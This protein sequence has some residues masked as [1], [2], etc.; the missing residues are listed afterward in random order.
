MRIPRIYF[1]IKITVG[2]ELYLT[3]EIYRHLI[4]V[5]KHNI[6][7]EVLIFNG[8]GG[9]YKSKILKKENN[10]Y[11]LILK[12]IDI[13]RESNIFI[14]LGLSLLP[15]KKMDIV[16]QKS[17]ELGVNKI[18][19]LDVSRSKVNNIQK[20]HKKL[21]HWKKII[22]SA[23]EQSGRTKIPKI[24]MPIKLHDWMREINENDNF[25]MFHPDSLQQY[26]EINQI[27]NTFKLLVGPEGGFSDEEID[28]GSSHRAKVISLSK[29]VMRA[30]TAAIFVVGLTQNLFGDM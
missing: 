12:F 7:D 10:F 25:I 28:I 22:V 15:S 3:K 18:T 23:V 8:L 21:L 20:Y 27:S 24:S 11:F 13:S 30:E 16:I 14:D 17:V 2:D 1:D 26:K 29:R 4:I 5:L 19:L 9:E 6:G